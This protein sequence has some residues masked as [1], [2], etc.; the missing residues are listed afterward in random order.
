MIPNEQ[1][2]KEEYSFI[3]VQMLKIEPKLFLMLHKETKK[4][5]SGLLSVV[6]NRKSIMKR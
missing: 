5:N 1:R 3:C 4:V 6:L 2:Y